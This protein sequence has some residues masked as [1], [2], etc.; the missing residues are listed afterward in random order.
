[1]R[2]GIITG[3]YPPM[4]G[5]VGAYTR[6]LA[7]HYAQ[8]GHDV[9]L[10]ADHRAREANPHIHLTAPV[11]RWNIKTLLHIRAWASQHQ[12]DVV[13]LQFET[14]AY[15]MSGWI[16]FLPLF[17]PNV[18]LVTT[19]HDLL[20]PYLFPKAGALRG[21][22]VNYLADRSSGVIVTNHEDYDKQSHLKQIALIPIG[23]NIPDT[24]PAEYDRPTWR[25]K[26]GANEDEF[27]IA[28]F[29]FLNQ[30]KGV[31][32]L[33][34]DTADLL[35]AGYKLKL[36]LIGDRVGTSDSANIHYAQTIDKL[37]TDLQLTPF[38]T[39]TGFIDEAEVSAYLQSADAVALPFTDGA[40]YR[41]GTLMAAIQHNR[42]IIT[43]AP[44][45][46]IPQFVDQE[47]MLFATSDHDGNLTIAP[48]IQA[49]YQQPALASRLQAGTQSLAQY[50]QWDS[51]TAQT[52]AFFQQVIDMRG[53][54]S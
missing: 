49:L 20:T 52:L 5:G 18:P 41:R 8:L 13:N 3:E 50:F 38:I 43:T 4:Q 1:M 47:N 26:A 53:K 16:H 39:W 32:R 45:V 9:F 10:Y 31:D 37:I 40:S 29:G 42:P 11:K 54:I 17:L 35:Q 19:F 44:K 25:K 51:I 30:S 34:K 15:Q 7:Q 22:I 27:L 36:V 24:L 12:L 6:I 21:K 28:Y 48:C 33:L 14:A 2:I 23:S 46:A